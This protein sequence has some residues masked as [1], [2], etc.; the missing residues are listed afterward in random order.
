MA[1]ILITGGCGFIGSH[2]AEV[3]LQRGHHVS[4]IDDLSTGSINNIAPL[5]R[6]ARFEHRIDSVLNRPLMAELIDAADQVYHLAAA[7]GVRL[8]VERPVETI[9]TNIRGTEVVLDLASRKG[10]PVLIA[11]SSEVYGKGAR[12]PFAE[13]DDCVL[14]PSIRPRWSYACSKLIDEFLALAH[15]KQRGL[16]TVVARFF[17]TVGPRQTGAYG[18]VIPRMI[19]AAQAGQPITVHGDGQQ[20]RTFCHVLDTVDA[21]TAL[22]AAPGAV[23]QV[24]NVGGEEEITIEALARLVIEVTGSSSEI[25]F[26]P[27]R[28]VFGEGFEDLRRR[29]P[30]TGRLRSLVDWSPQR[31]LRQIIE[32]AVAECQRERV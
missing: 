28:E 20:T 1:H 11:S 7:V 26:V 15:H 17:N 19:D 4:V 25:R 30:D 8:I 10:K 31:T 21:I 29:V 14:G 3:L 24:F 2:L 9:E 18:M 27:Y 12:I 6:H 23:G 32:D 13:D 16:P 22:M 5:R